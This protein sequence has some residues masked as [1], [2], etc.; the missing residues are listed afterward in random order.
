MVLC[1]P[2]TAGGINRFPSSR[3]RSLLGQDDKKPSVFVAFG[4]G[5]KVAYGAR[6]VLSGTVE[7]RDLCSRYRLTFFGLENTLYGYPT[8]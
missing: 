7:H 5:D 2:A 1:L 4:P 8:G 3:G 6:G